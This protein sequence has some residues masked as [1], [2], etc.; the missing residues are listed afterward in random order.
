MKPVAQRVL[1]FPS[2]EFP[3]GLLP[4]LADAVAVM[5]TSGSGIHPSNDAVS[6]EPGAEPPTQLAAVPNVPVPPPQMIVD[7]CAVT[8]TA[9]ATVPTRQATPS[10]RCRRSDAL[11]KR[12]I[13]LPPVDSEVRDGNLSCR[14]ARGCGATRQ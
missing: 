14:S 9:A 5:P 2:M 3:T 1:T 11:A 7:P 10:R 4:S 12:F 6:L 8:A 13:A